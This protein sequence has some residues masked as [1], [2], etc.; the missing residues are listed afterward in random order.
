LKAGV[1]AL[2]AGLA[3]SVACSDD[4]P[5]EPTQTEVTARD[6]EFLD[7]PEDDLA[8]GSSFTMKNTSTVEAHEMIAIRIPDDEDRSVE[9]IAELSE[10]EQNAIFGDSEPSFVLISGPGEDAMAVLG[11]GTFTE[12]GRYALV[13]FVPTGADPEEFLNSEQ[14]DVEGGP[15]HFAQGMHAEVTVVAVDE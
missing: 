11:D 6:Y 5:P 3:L 1:V 13:C 12:A 7:V 2:I 14:G 4:D 8:V 10:D 15:P 9:E